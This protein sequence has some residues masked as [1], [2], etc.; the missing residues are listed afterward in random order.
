MR[1]AC[2]PVVEWVVAFGE[3]LRGVRVGCQSVRTVGDPPM[4]PAEASVLEDVIRHPDS[5][6]SDISGRTGF[7]QS[8]VSVTVARLRDRGII[9]TAADAADGRRVQVRV[10]RTAM[11][12]ITRRSRQ[13]IDA[14]LTDVLADAGSARRVTALLDELAALLL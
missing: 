14:A 9:E 5:S 6:I 13:P 11:R 8:H 12:S 1:V 10:A 7:A 3:H 2:S 4:A